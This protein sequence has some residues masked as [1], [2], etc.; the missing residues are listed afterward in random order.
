[1]RKKIIEAIFRIASDEFETIADVKELAMMS[2]EELLDN[3]VSIID[4]LKNELDDL[5]S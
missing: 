1:M 5:N 4:Y 3:L 2:D